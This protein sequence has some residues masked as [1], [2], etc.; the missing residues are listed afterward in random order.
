AA[1]SV[2]GGV[3]TAAP[4]KVRRHLGGGPTRRG[5]RR[6]AVAGRERTGCRRSA[7]DRIT[8]FSLPPGSGLGTIGRDPRGRL[9]RGR[10][11]ERHR[12]T[13][14]RK[15]K[16]RLGKLVAQLGLVSSLGVGLAELEQLAELKHMA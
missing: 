7:S 3:P 13:G 5:S 2:Q 4:R 16:A 11:Q 6:G 1:V 9:C 8:A 12:E 14:R 10:A 15:S